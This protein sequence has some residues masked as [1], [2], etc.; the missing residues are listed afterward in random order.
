MPLGPC[1]PP[2]TYAVGPGSQVLFMSALVVGG[3]LPF[4]KQF[5]MALAGVPFI[6]LGMPMYCQ[7]CCGGKFLP[8]SLCA[9]FCLTTR[10]FG[11]LFI[12]LCRCVSRSLAPWLT[13]CIILACSARSTVSFVVPISWNVCSSLII[14][15]G[16]QTSC[17]WG[18]ICNPLAK[19]VSVIMVDA[20][21][22]GLT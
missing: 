20:M 8:L 13:S 7:E 1:R 16:L 9:G 4:S 15:Y 21:L 12:A 11:P 2:D 6:N 18:V 3:N 14:P 22:V 10:L 5:V 19:A 17:L